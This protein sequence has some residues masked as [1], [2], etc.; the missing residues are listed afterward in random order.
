M[1]ILDICVLCG[2]VNETIDHLF[3]HCKFSNSLWCRFIA[4]C[5]VLWSLPRLLVGL[6]KAWRFF[7]FFGSGLI[8]WRIIPFAIV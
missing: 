3:V 8:L 6:V 4:R 1:A 2:K 5:G 7:S